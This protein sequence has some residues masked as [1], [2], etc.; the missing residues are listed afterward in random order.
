LIIQTFKR[1]RQAICDDDKPL[2]C[3]G[4]RDHGSPLCEIR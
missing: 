4:L 3:A 1:K 2:C